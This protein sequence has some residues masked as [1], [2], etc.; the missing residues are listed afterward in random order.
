MSETK[1]TCDDLSITVETVSCLGACGLA[2][3]ITVNEQFYPS[4]TPDKASN[5]P[6]AAGGTAMLKNREGLVELRARCRGALAAEE[7]KILVCAGT[8]CVSSGSLDLY[9]RLV[10]V[11]RDR[12]HP[13]SVELMEDSH[14]GSIGLKKSGCHG[15]CEMGPLIRIEPEGYLY[16]KVKLSDARKS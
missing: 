1:R 4:M 8:G 13:C 10:T 6:Y 3:V 2:P 5:Y 16:T 12:H 7:R 9:D 15:F 11:I 14:E